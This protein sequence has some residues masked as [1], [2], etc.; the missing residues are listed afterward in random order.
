VRPD[1]EPRVP[2][3][4]QSGDLDLESYVF[5]TVGDIIGDKAMSLHFT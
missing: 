1:F 2:E 5:K 4:Q 3:V